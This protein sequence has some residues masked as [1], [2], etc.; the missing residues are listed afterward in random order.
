MGNRRTLQCAQFVNDGT[1]P[2]PQNPIYPPI[3]KTANPVI[4]KPD[5]PVDTTT[6]RRLWALGI[7]GA[8]LT[9]VVAVLLIRRLRSKEA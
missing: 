2:G 9:I 8:G 7:S 3:Q 6:P 1:M 5:L 4:V